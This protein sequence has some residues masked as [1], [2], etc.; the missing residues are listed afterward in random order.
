VRVTEVGAQ[1]DLVFSR[2]VPR[3]LAADV[4]GDGVASFG[5]DPAQLSGDGFGCDSGILAVEL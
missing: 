4:M 1:A 3:E 5:G 2:L